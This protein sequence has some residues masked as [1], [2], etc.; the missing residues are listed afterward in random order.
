MPEFSIR[1]LTK[2]QKRII[3][4][5]NKQ[6]KN[7]VKQRKKRSQ[8]RM[9]G[10]AVTQKELAEAVAVELIPIEQKLMTPDERARYFFEEMH[11]S[12]KAQQVVYG[13]NKKLNY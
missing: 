4:F 11:K 6:N 9:T 5:R 3:Q 8:N 2:E 13:V 10:K 12:D 1:F 7:K